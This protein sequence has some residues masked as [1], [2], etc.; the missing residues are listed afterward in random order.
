MAGVIKFRRQEIVQQLF[1]A[2]IQSLPLILFAMSIVITMSLLEF[3]WHMKKVLGQ[4]ELVPA[5][6]LVL[7]LRETAPVVTAMLLASRLG[8]TYASQIAVMKLT[9]QLDAL[10]IL[11]VSL[12]EFLFIPRLVGCLGATL[13]L[14]LISTWVSLGAGALA[15]AWKLNYQ[16]GEFLNV[17]FAFAR[18]PDVLMALVKA[19]GFGAIIATAGFLAGVRAKPGSRGVGEAATR[20]VVASSL[21]IILADFLINALWRM[22]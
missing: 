13:M 12:L 16:L 8:A 20:S 17:S 18:S 11:Q 9:E 5:F 4:D 10:K 14:T 19:L 7:T 1:D 3:S 2:C 6:S 22:L 21:G 15:A